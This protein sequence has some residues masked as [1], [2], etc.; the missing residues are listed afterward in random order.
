MSPRLP[1]DGA[2]ADG[3]KPRWARRDCAQRLLT[4]ALLWFFA[5]SVRADCTSPDAQE[6]MVLTGEALLKN[7]FPEASTASFQC[8]IGY[9]RARGSGTTSCIGGKWTKV[10]LK[11]EKKSCGSPGEVQNGRFDFTDGIE[12]GAI[13]K[14]IC[15]EGYV[16]VGQDYRE[17][18][19]KGWTGRIP[20]CEV[21]QCEEP[22][23]IPNGKIVFRPSS[24]FPQYRDTIQ[25]ECNAGYTLVG[26]MHIMCNATGEYEPQAPACSKDIICETPKVPNGHRIGGA[27]A[28]YKLD[29][30]VTFE[31]DNGY[32]MDGR[33]EMTCTVDGWSQ[34]PTCKPVKCGKPPE[35]PNGRIVSKPPS[36][37]PQYLDTIKYE[38]NAGYMLVGKMQITC[39]AD[40]KY[41]QA[42]ECRDI[43]CESPKVLNGH[44]IDGARAPY[45]LDNFVTFAC[46]NGYEMDGRAEMTCTVDG[47]SHWPTCKPVKCGKPP[48]V[49]NG[50][51]VSGHSS[52]FP[53]YRDTIKYECNAGYMLVGK[54]QITCNADRK[55]EQAPECRDIIC[56]TPKVPNGHPVEG[57]LPPYKLHYSVTFECDNGYEMDGRAQMTCTVDGWSHWPTCKP[58]NSNSAVI[59]LVIGVA[60][61]AVL[62]A[63]GG[64]VL[65]GIHKKKTGTRD[66]QSAVRS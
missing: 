4:A 45:K 50:K 54:M 11:C 5:G 15:N 23:E 13:V 44:R 30:F 16:I 51:I 62:T 65:Y 61:L 22:P 52:E 60:V 48:E 46:N 36:E 29:N 33:A 2:Q 47:W 40:R 38:C 66:Y 7:N 55:Y 42:P 8:S 6:N 10:T 43:I 3:L 64:C 9:V 63:I 25:Y 24:E 19:D 41:E 26:K 59:G 39:N 1:V 20:T 28:P 12:F 56:E 35:V 32:E 58:G 31:C 17:C 53:Q 49:P 18:L 14:A 37:F 27:R 34:G 57:A 21:V